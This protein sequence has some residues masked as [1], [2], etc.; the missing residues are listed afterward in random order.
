MLEVKS[1]CDLNKKDIELFYL[2][3]SNIVPDKRRPAHSNMWSDNWE[4]NPETLPYI[5]NKTSRFKHPNGTFQVVFDNN[6]IVACSGVYISDFS[7]K[8]AIG[9]VRS[10]VEQSYRNQ[11]LIGNIVLPIHRKWAKE[12]GM[13]ILA[14]TFNQYNRNLKRVWTRARLG[15]NL[16]SR[17]SGNLPYI[18]SDNF[19]ELNFMVTIQ[20]VKQWV[21]YEKFTEWDYEWTSIA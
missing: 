5:L 17:V 10:W 7:P 6:Q 9:G 1:F 8:V 21:I 20:Y 2:Y 16:T 15:E 4:N 18:F 12:N 3:L 19:N 11:S 13:N 14:L